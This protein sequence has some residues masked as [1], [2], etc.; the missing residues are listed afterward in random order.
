MLHEIDEDIQ[1]IANRAK[2]IHNEERR[3]TMQS[4]LIVGELDDRK[5]WYSMGMTIEQLSTYIGISSSQYYK[6]LKA[7]RVL[8]RHPKSAELFEKG[9]IQVSQLS[10][11]AG[12]ITQAN[13]ELLLNGIRNLTKRETEDFVTR[14]T[15][16]GRLREGETTVEM[17]LRMTVSQRSV[18][19]R[20]QEVV[21]HRGRTFTMM[22][23]L[24]RSAEIYLEEHDPMRKAERAADREAAK[25]VR[26]MEKSEKLACKERGKHKT[27]VERKDKSSTIMP[28]EEDG[29]VYG[30]GSSWEDATASAEELAL[31]AEIAAAI[32]TVESSAEESLPVQAAAVITDSSSDAYWNAEEPPLINEAYEHYSPGE[33]SEVTPLERIQKIYIEKRKD[34]RRPIRTSVRNRVW[35]R[36]GGR[37]TF[38]HGNGERCKAKMMLELDHKVMV[39]RGGENTEENLTLRCRYHNQFVAELNLGADFMKRKREES[40]ANLQPDA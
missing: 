11:I 17:T 16:D 6:R 18:F 10:T 13:A 31:E 28:L 36:D 14:V 5:A 37:C 20:L 32:G 24:L 39:C 7:Y 9:E 33:L 19:D 23:A 25:A 4:V 30:T 2:T 21:A 29:T 34:P 1:A 12:R 27:E 40:A 8:K 38:T 26:D 35:L 22:G 15:A 3:I